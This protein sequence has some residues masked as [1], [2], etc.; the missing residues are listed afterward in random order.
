MND[1]APEKRNY[2]K[3][4]IPLFRREAFLLRDKKIKRLNHFGAHVL[5]V[6]FAYWDVDNRYYACL[7]S[8]K[9]MEKL[10]GVE[11]SSWYRYK[12]YFLKIGLYEEYYGRVKVRHYSKYKM[13]NAMRLI[14]YDFASL[15]EEL[16]HLQLYE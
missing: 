10:T 3:G 11:R 1:G 6:L 13:E 15:Q 14:G 12:Q 16:A 7:R 8:D 5:L 2:P 4:F 9:A